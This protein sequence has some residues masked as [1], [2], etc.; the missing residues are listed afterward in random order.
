[1]LAAATGRDACRVCQLEVL[2]AAHHG[3]RGSPRWPR[4]TLE[5]PARRQPPSAGAPAGPTT[6]RLCGS[7]AAA[8]VARRRSPS[9]WSAHTPAATT[10]RGP[11]ARGVVSTTERRSGRAMGTALTRPTGIATAS[12][13]VRRLPIL[14]SIGA[15]FGGDPETGRQAHGSLSRPWARPVR[16]WA[17]R[18]ARD[19]NTSPKT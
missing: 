12:A 11:R 13:C 17:S 7:C 18:G 9:R 19:R 1:V 6:P 3:S 10:C 14:I 16:R 15:A 4:G 8:L 2:G 5:G